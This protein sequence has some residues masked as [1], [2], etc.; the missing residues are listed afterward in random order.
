MSQNVN[1]NMLM[2]MLTKIQIRHQPSAVGSKAVISNPHCSF[3]M[4]FD[5]LAC[6]RSIVKRA[7]NFTW[8]QRQ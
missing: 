2:L 1:V 8:Q 4:C 6:C 7:I 5:V 3:W